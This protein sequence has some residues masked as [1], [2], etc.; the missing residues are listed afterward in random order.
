M[1]T[2]KNLEEIWK[3]FE[4]T[5]GNLDYCKKK[6]SFNN[7]YMNFSFNCYNSHNKLKKKLSC[8]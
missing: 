2:F 8:I 4:K 6:K 1:C 5:S 7:I 3:I